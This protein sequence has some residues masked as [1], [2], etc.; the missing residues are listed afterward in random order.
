M[1]SLIHNLGIRVVFIGLLTLLC[2]TQ[3]AHADFVIV[4]NL[5]FGE[6]VI[7]D[8]Y[9]PHH[10]TV[11]PDGSYTHAPNFIE[12]DPPQPGI[13]QIDELEPNSVINVTAS[14]LQPMMG[15]NN[16]FTL[17]NIQVIHSNVD[18][19]G[20]ADIMLGADAVTSGNGS[21]YVG[22]TYSGQILIQISY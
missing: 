15:N 8:N 4:Q 7:Q 10:L 14:Q 19:A 17:E 16:F 2:S 1:H 20:L 5:H 9:K 18:E 3:A 6:F 12:I 22:D 13:Y 21:K 11:N